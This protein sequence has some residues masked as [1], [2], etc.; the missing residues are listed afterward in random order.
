[1]SS[2]VSQGSN[3]ER[4]DKSKQICLKNLMRMIIKSSYPHSLCLFTDYPNEF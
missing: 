4:F 2:K 1:M 3:F